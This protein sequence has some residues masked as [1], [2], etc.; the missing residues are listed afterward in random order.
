MQ[1]EEVKKQYAD[2]VKAGICPV[3]KVAK[4]ETGK[5]CSSCTKKMCEKRSLDLRATKKKVFDHYGGKCVCCS[6]STLTFLALDHIEGG[7][8]KHRKDLNTGCGYRFYKWIVKNGFPTGFQIL[9]HNC[10]FAKTVE[11]GC[12]YH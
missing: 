2:R 12:A 4:P 5:I 1:N 9:C 6:E 7:G 8:E 10:H 11:G 3:C